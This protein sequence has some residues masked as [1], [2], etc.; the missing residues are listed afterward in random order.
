MILNFNTGG[1]YALHELD[2]TFPQDA[3]VASGTDATF[4]VSISNPG[5]PAFYTYQWYVD[6]SAVDGA[7]GPTYVRNTSSDKG[8]YTVYCEVTNK[9]G[10]VTSRNAKLTVNKKPVLSGSYPESKTVDVGESATFDVTIS[11]AGYP[12]TYKYQWYVNGSPVSGAINSSY[13]RS[14]VG[15][16]EFK[17]YCEVTNA[18]GSVN[19]RTATLI[20]NK[21]YILKSGD[22]KNLTGGWYKDA[23]SEDDESSITATNNRIS[24]PKNLWAYVA[25]INSINL[26]DY[27]KIYFKISAGPVEYS[28]GGSYRVG[29]ILS[30]TEL[31]GYNQVLEFK[32]SAAGN[33]NSQGS[34]IDPLTYSGTKSVNISAVDSGYIALY[35]SMSPLSC[36]EIYME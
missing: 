14:N 19:S 28:G 30:K 12:D 21:L 22:V 3:T 11:T 32:A 26:K 10:V 17:V 7:T 34:K 36:S 15:K 35:S 8:V 24:I 18:A 4:S 23:S 13:T 33:L 25:S 16:G 20:G 5:K 27:S 29:I 1:S 31:D 2:N 6:G 9:A